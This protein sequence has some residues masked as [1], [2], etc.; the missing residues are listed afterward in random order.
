MN[1]A[2]NFLQS[3]D[4]VSP[5]ILTRHLVKKDKAYKNARNAAN[6][7]NLANRRSKIAFYNTVNATMNN[8][9]ISAKKKFS[10]LTKL[11]KNSKFSSIAPLNEND[12]IINEPKQKSE[13]LNQ[14][15]ASKSKVNG[16]NDAPPYLEK[17]DGV[18]NLAN[19][20][21]SPIEISKLIRG[22]KKSHI[23]PCGISGKFLHIISKE[24]S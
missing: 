17:I 5:E 19:I 20:N 18:Q 11:M 22:L 13:I 24:I 3:Q 4:N 1:S 14:Y 7:S 10:I 21:T 2:Y 8:F 9:S 6:S 23:S 15:F 16:K 12:A